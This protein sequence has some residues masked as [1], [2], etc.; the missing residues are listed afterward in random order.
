MKPLWSGADAR[1]SSPATPATRRSTSPSPHGIDGGDAR[2]VS[3]GADRVARSVSSD[4]RTVLFRLSPTST[5]AIATSGWC[6]S[7]P[8]KSLDCCSTHGSTSTAPS[9]LPTIDRWRTSPTNP[10]EKKS[11]SG[12]FPGSR[13]AASSRRGGAEP[14]WSRDGKELFYRNGDRMMAVQILSTD[15]EL[16]AAPP[17]ALF[18]RGKSERELRRDRGRPLRDDPGGPNRIG[19]DE[20][21]HRAPLDRG[22]EGP[23]PK[24]SWRNA[25]Y[26]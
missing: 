12:D 5:A 3:T 26:C 16:V 7:T 17:K 20:L 1:L 15:P 19:D 22:A 2:R 13:T 10:A 18:E 6:A 23:V 21:P 14:L 25:S 9:S 24:P 11:T 8:T 4:G